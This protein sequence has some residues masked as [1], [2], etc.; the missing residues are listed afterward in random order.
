MPK[1]LRQKLRAELKPNT[2]IFEVQPTSGVLHPGEKSNVQVKFMPKEEVSFNETWF[3]SDSTSLSFTQRPGSIGLQ[4]SVEWPVPRCSDYD[5]PSA[6]GSC[7]S[8]VAW[9][10]REPALELAPT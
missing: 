8:C 2:R 1:Y 5:I 4:G 7:R 3:H 10:L 6:S 9:R